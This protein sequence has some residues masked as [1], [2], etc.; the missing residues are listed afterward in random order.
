[1]GDTVVISRIDYNFLHG[2]TITLSLIKKIAA[3]DNSNYGYSDSTSKMIDL[4]LDI[5]RKKETD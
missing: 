1:M 5:E 3:N 2:Q 4:L